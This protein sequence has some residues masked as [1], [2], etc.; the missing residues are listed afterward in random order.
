MMPAR[1]GYQNLG[2]TAAISA[3]S[4]LLLAPALRLKNPDV[5][6]KWQAVG[7]AA[8]LTYDLGSL[9]TI[10]CARLMGLTASTARVR[11]SASDPTSGD[12]GDSGV[13]AVDQRF[14][15]FTDV[16]DVSARYVR[17]DLTS[18]TVCE[19]GRH[20]IGPLDEF[21]VNFSYGWTRQWIDPSDRKKTE[22]GTTRINRRAKS[23][24]FSTQF[25]WLS[26]TE[27]RGFLD[28]MERTN[29]LTDDVLLI[30]DPE[31]PAI[32]Q[33]SIWGLFADLSQVAQPYFDKWSKKITIEQ[34]L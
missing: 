23:R 29:G 17:F 27:M 2:D 22:A 13:V 18:A 5:A 26:E 28:D 15:T 24:M 21:E 9:Q 10:G 20:Y 6:V 16:R 14:L 30:T 32:E 33:D 8:S 7:G 12:L 25:D 11:Y 34:R 3:S 31:S 19:A 4:Q 1:I